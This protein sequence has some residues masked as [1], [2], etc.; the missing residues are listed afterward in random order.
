MK[1]CSFTTPGHHAR[2]RTPA[3]NGGC[4]GG[5]P[6]RK[7]A[8]PPSTAGPSTWSLFWQ[9]FALPGQPTERCYIT[10]D[11]RNAVDQHWESFARNL[12]TGAKVI[13]LGCGA[14]VTGRILTESRAD[15]NVTGIDWANVPDTIAGANITI[16]RGLNMEALPFDDASFDAAL[17]LFGIEYA[18]IEKTV[19]ELSRLLK[20]GARYSFVVHHRASGIVEEGSTRRNAL[21]DSIA[22]RMTAAFVAGSLKGVDDQ[23]LRL[24]AKYPQEPVVDLIRNYLLRHISCARLVRLSISQKLASDFETEFSLLTQLE[25]SAKSPAE[26]GAWLISFLSHMTSVRAFVLRRNSGEPI[27]WV[28]DGC[29]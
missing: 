19:L 24:K 18:N 20:P 2:S 12:P 4:P 15:L 17:S 26:M 1:L 27:A 21:W 13:D 6:F 23:R 3:I 29:R 10:G 11:A 14:G 28:V 16:C 22:G 7:I 25:K 8:F 5:K 9:E